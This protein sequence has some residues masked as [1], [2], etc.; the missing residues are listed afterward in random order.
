MRVLQ[1][2]QSQIDK[3]YFDEIGLSGEEASKLTPE[4]LAQRYAEYKVKRGTPLAPWSWGDEERLNKY[5]ES[6]K[7]I[8]KER[9]DA[10]G[11]ATVN[12]AYADFEARY[13]AVSEKAKE[14]KA[15]MRTDYA[16]AA[17]AHAAL[18]QD[19]D[20]TLYQRF[21]SLDKQLG[22]I[23]KMWLT[24]KTPEEAALIASTIPA[25]RAGM[26]KVLQAETVENQ[27][28]AMSE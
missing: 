8:M 28:S 6:A 4:Q 9:L 27:Q 26:V 13:K 1:V 24:S 7:D 17:Q 19:P 12:E 18:Q 23:S 22:R 10:Q 3:M 20:F 16:A 14:A 21:G 11:D 25:Y 2:P 5:S 15:L